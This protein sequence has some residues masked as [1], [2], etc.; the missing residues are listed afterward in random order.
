MFSAALENAGGDKLQLTNNND[1]EGVEIDGLYP[2]GST[3]NMSENSLF[4][5]ARFVSSKVDK[6]PVTVTFYIARNAEENRIKLYR[7]IQPGQF[8]RLY[9]KNGSRNVYIDGYVENFEI[10]F[11]NMKQF[12][13]VAMLCPIPYFYD[14]SASETDINIITNSFNFPF[15]IEKDSPVALGYLEDISEIYLINNGDVKT[16]MKIEITATGTVRNPIIYNAVTNEFFKLNYEMAAGEI[17]YIS[18]EKG[19][20][21]V[22]TLKEGSYINIFNK[23]A[24]GSTWFQL[25]LGTNVFKY[26]ADAQDENYMTVKFAFQQLYRGV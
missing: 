3:L 5:G 17:V 26:D 4:D 6:K 24:E 2:S 7:I 8:L 18:T 13:T 19:K 20:K 23:I 11:F 15:A 12:A 22:E 25:E 21:T 9:Y 10:E 16:G 14:N 1:Y